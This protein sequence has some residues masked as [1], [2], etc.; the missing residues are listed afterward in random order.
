MR[1]LAIIGS[2]FIVLVLASNGSATAQGAAGDAAPSAAEEDPSDAPSFLLRPMPIEGDFVD[3]WRQTFA[4]DSRV[5]AGDSVT[6]WVEDDWLVARRDSASGAVDWQV[7]LC[8]VNDT[9]MPMVAVRN[10]LAYFD[11]SYGNGR[12]FIRDSDH[13][14]RCRR[15]PKHGG[16]LMNKADMVSDDVAARS[17]AYSGISGLQF[18][19]LVHKDWY[20]VVT[21]PSNNRWNS[22]VR[23]NP[24]SKGKGSGV[25]MCATGL[26]HW[27]HGDTWLIDDGEL[28]VASRTLEALY[29][30]KKKLAD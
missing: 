6:L 8:Q 28:I 30:A 2:S 12:Y 26:A 13:V 29:L 27:H 21:G 7:Y 24:D 18:Y 22:F 4:I 25:L 16:K 19:G 15:M 23:L 14:F 1:T 20:Y 9:E 17:S 5:T 10:G 3:G 11:V